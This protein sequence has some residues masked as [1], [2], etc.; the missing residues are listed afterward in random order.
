MN[1]IEAIKILKDNS[2]V[3]FE[4]TLDIAINLKN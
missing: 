3:K 4:E 2:Y 1:P